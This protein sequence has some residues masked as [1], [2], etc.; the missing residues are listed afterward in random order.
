MKLSLLIFFPL[1]GNSQPKYSIHK[2]QGGADTL[3]MTVGNDSMPVSSTASYTSAMWGNI[4]GNMSRQKDLQAVINNKVSSDTPTFTGN[5]GIGT[6]LPTYK[7]DVRGTTSTSGLKLDS[8]TNRRVIIEGDSYSVFSTKWPYQLPDSMP[9]FAKASIT[10]YGFSGGDVATMRDDYMSQAHLSRPARG[11]D[12]WFFIYAGI[13]DLA[14]LNRSADSIYANLKYIWANARNDNYKVVAFTVINSLFLSAPKEA[15]RVKLNN[16]ILGDPSLY[17][18]CVDVAAVF[19]PRIDFTMFDDNTH[20]S[21]TGF[22]RMAG[23]VANTLENIPYNLTSADSI[24]KSTNNFYPV[25]KNAMG[26]KKM[27]KAQR[28]AMLNQFEGMAIYQTDQI[29]GVR[30]RNGNGWVR[31]TETTD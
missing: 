7:L 9:F 4:H 23:V 30:V 26:L 21:P 19:D 3:W 31:F 15:Q 18:Y 10:N 14:G 28:D 1:I 24:S 13:N 17:D 27:T 11:D 8:F 20:L 25:M 12:F 5:V 29:P 16:L 22:K 6:S 2:I